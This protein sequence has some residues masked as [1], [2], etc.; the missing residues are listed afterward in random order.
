M[1][2]KGTLAAAVRY[3]GM[4]N[5]DR[6]KQRAAAEREFARQQQKADA[7]VAMAEYRAA[8][9]ALRERTRQ[10]REQRLARDAREATAMPPRRS[11]NR[12]KPVADSRAD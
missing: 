11:R 9:D 12:P 3:I 6:Q 5:I 4:P 1:R 8:Q 2:A 10:L 7:P